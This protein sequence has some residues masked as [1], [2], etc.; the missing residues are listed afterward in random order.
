MIIKLSTRIIHDRV[1]DMRL[2]SDIEI[3]RR[4]NGKMK[5]ARSPRT[6]MRERNRQG[7]FAPLVSLP[8]GRYSA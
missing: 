2:N 1:K 7:K 5:R 3:T 6:Q 8:D 4:A